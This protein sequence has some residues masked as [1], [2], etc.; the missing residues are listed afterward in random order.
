MF[1]LALLVSV[2]QPDHMLNVVHFVP[3]LAC[4]HHYEWHHS[5]VTPVAR[6][7]ERRNSDV[8]E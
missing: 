4:G 5:P 1:S 6:E 8:Y 7:V 2:L 3:H